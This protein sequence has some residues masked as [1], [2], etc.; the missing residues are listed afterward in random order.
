L[1]ERQHRQPKQDQWVVVARG[2]IEM[3]LIAAGAPMD[4]H[5]LS[6]PSNGDADRLHQR[7]AVGR[8]VAGRVVV[9]VTTPEA[10]GAMVPMRCSGCV[11]GHVEAAMPA[12]ERTGS[13]SIA[14][15]SMI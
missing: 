1:G 11:L 15:T 13:S 6:A 3:D 2:S 9:Y 8:S 12:A 5:P 10:G 14:A 7:A 4:E